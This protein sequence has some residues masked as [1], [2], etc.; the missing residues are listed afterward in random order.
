MNKGNTINSEIHILNE[1][2]ANKLNFS[3]LFI[4]VGLLMS[5]AV[6]QAPIMIAVNIVSLLVYIYLF[7][8]IKKSLV[9][10]LI[11]TFAEI[12]FHMVI[13]TICMGWAC[14]FQLYC[15]A[16]V[17][18][19]YYAHYISMRFKKA[20]YPLPMII[21]VIF[22]YLVTNFYSMFYNP[23]YENISQTTISVIYIINSIV[24]FSFLII[25]FLL[26]EKM[27][28]SIEILLKN[29]AEYDVLTGL[30]N[31]YRM[32]SIFE[33]LLKVEHNS[34]TEFSIGILDIDNFKKVNDTYGHNVGDL[35]L[36]NVADVLH[37][38][39]KDNI[40]A[41]RWGGEEF[42]L[43]VTG[44]NSLETAKI[45]LELIRVNVANKV[46]EADDNKIS[47][48]ISSG[49]TLHINGENLISTVERAD[50]YLYTAKK[51]G[52]N[53]VFTGDN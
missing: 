52:K 25:F 8:V 46:T 49:V 44:N 28:L 31:R 11:F 47:V 35:I 7:R 12:L 19:I 42:L 21:A 13:A 10:Y 45:L 4:H 53:K 6:M 29:T 3:I 37:D 36:K 41:C 27:G 16:V 48:T 39:E 43:L 30:S 5:F 2:M 50:S 9:A 23:I 15:F 1:E 20:F 51:S 33:Q 14:G 22:S 17:P 40:Y 26:Y 34:T 18:L 24:V 32:N 38:V